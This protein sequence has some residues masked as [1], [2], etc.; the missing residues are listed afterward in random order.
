MNQHVERHLVEFVIPAE[1]A[2]DFLHPENVILRFGKGGNTID[3]GA[4]CYLRRLEP[5][6][7]RK[8][9][10]ALAVDPSSFDGQRAKKVREIVRYFSDQASSSGKKLTTLLTNARMFLHFIDW[11]DSHDHSEVMTNAGTARLAFKS[12]TNFLRE[13]IQ[14]D[15]LNV[16]TASRY[17]SHVLTCLS[18]LLNLDDLNRGVR[19]LRKCNIA[20]K[21]TEVPDSESQ[22]KVLSLCEMLFEGISSLVI[23]QKPYVHQLA[24]PGY[25]GWK[26]N[27]VW[28]FP[29]I[30]AFMSPHDANAREKLKYSNWAINYAEG[31]L[32]K[33]AEIES[34]YATKSAAMKAIRD[35]RATIAQANADS[36]HF[37]RRHIA[38]LAHNCFVLLFV[39]STGM[40]WAVIREL[41]WTA[42][43]EV[44][45]ESQG[46]RQIKYR[47]GGRVV[48]FIIKTNFLPKFKRYL[49]LRR[50]LLNNSECDYLFFTMGNRLSSDPKQIG[51][52]VL[53]SLQTTLRRIDPSLSPILARAWRAA[54]SDWLIKNTDPS[55]TALLLQNSERTVLRHYIAGSETEATRE[56]S[57][58][59]NR[60]SK[61][62][63]H[64]HQ[65]LDSGWLDSPLGECQKY[66]EPKSLNDN[67]P[68]KPDCHQPEGCLF[69]DKYVA[70]ADERDARKLLSCQHCIYLTRHLSASDDH[71]RA[72]FGEIIDRIEAIINE[73]GKKSHSHS[74]LVERIKR[75]VHED[76]LLDPYW[77]NKV[78]MLISLGVVS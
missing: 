23:E 54:K 55:T 31:R 62:V 60:V 64:E 43:F 36:Q 39:A 16:N 13:Q 72:M 41:K 61:I 70:H 11:C 33:I 20:S 75:E 32:A 18:E 69:C 4:R 78:Q 42:N 48:S 57:G 12:Y 24:L 34:H 50:Y 22:G 52:F 53:E 38:M 47:A 76:G 35:A 7:Q 44:G 66:G 19:Q 8:R 30:K 71:F 49:E 63:L 9:A 74:Q 28:L 14:L 37:Q 6:S 58:F 56:M 59:F 45:A 77:D 26:N 5:G 15:K 65:K 21:T 68:I 17:Q 51:P 25:L 2:I 29:T 73:I 27:F 1:S 10:G 67:G 3:V 40:N 46:F